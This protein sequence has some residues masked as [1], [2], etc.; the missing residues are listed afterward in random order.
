MKRLAATITFLLVLTS[1]TSTTYTGQGGQFQIEVAVDLVNVNFSA[2]D[3]R[4]RMITGLKEEDFIVE[5]DGKPQTV[6]LF[7]REQELPLTLGILL[8]VSPSVA[9]VFEEEKATASAFLESVLGKRDLATVITFDR[10]VILA[11]DYTEDLP[12][13]KKSIHDLK[14]SRPGTSLYD[15]VYLAAGEKL[16]HEAGRKAIVLIS[17]GEDTTSTYNMSKA[18]I[19]AHKSNVVIYTISNAGNSGTLRRLA[20]ETGG[21]FYRFRE[22]G[23]FEKVFQQIALELRTQYSIAYHSTNAVRDGSFRRIKIIPRNSNINVRSRRG[24]Y[25]P[26]DSSSR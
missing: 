13:L 23:D 26:S 19:A 17:D 8:D 15:A 16:S 1:V 7:A 9:S 10:S 3:S 21:M 24:Y 11:Q 18:L 25:A 20:E 14:L 5:E 12:S 2:T 22:S 6:T 4:G